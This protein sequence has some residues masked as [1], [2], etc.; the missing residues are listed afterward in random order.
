MFRFEDHDPAFL[1]AYDSD[2]EA[3]IESYYELVERWKARFALGQRFGVI[4]V[5]EPHEHADGEAESHERNVAFEEA[6]SK[7]LTDFR[8]DH[9][10]DVEQS[11]A[12]YARVL[13]AAYINER[14]K[15][16]P[17]YMETARASTDRMT[18][19]MWGVPG[20]LFADLDEAR[21]WLKTQIDAMPVHAASA[22]DTQPAAHNIG[23]FYGSTT[24]VTEVAALQIADTWQ[25][26]TG[27]NLHTVNIGTV[28]DASMLLRYDT[29][30]L[31]IPTWNVGQLQDDWAI[32]MPQLESLDFRGKTVALF[33]VGDQYGYPENYLDA[34][35]TL[36]DALTARGASLIGQWNDGK[37]E[38]VASKAFANGQFIGLALDE[39]QQGEHSERRI[40]QWVTQLVQTLN[41]PMTSATLAE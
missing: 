29:L 13:P 34:M 33:G 32:V 12:A 1:I 19:Y 40:N 2:H 18:R 14:L 5:T 10:T 15:I 39:V 28:K 36:G 27:A 26:I 4:L 25:A 35:G 8:R 17:D 22:E 23:L 24:G 16:A 3:N 30:I 31:G 38:F 41:I 11:T 37:Y 7:L 9:K 6:F 21:T 20:S